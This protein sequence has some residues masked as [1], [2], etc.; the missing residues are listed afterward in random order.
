VRQD[1]VH[2]YPLGNPFDDQ[3]ATLQ[4]GTA[5]HNFGLKEDFTYAKGIQ[6]LKIGANIYQT[7]LAENFRLGITDPAYNSPSNAPMGNLSSA[8]RGSR[9]PFSLE[10]SLAWARR[11]ADPR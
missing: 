2:Y 6:N 3:P 11:L 8:R 7:P 5:T 10:P 9:V 1:Q 4:T